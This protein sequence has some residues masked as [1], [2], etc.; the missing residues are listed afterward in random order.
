MFT[1]Y[2]ASAGS[3]KTTSLVAAYLALCFTNPDKYRNILAI[4]FTNNATAEMKKRITD[5]LTCFAFQEPKYFTSSEK[6]IY[7][8]TTQYLSSFFPPLYSSHSWLQNQAKILLNK[9]LYD[10][11]N[12]SISTID[13]FFQRLIR[14]F[15]FDLGL[16]INFN[17]QIELEELYA[18]TVDTLISK[19]SKQNKELSDRVLAVLHQQMENTGR[20]KIEQNLVGI[21]NASY[22]EEAY[23][24]LKAL[25]NMERTEF[26]RF[27][28]ELQQ[29]FAATKKE[30]LQLAEQGEKLIQATGLEIDDFVGVSRGIYPY[31]SKLKADLTTRQNNT[32]QKNDSFTKQRPIDPHIHAQ[33]CALLTQIQEQQTL[34]SEYY[35]FVQ[36]LVSLQL[37]FDLREIMDGIKLRD[38]LFYLSEANAKVYDEIKDQEA[39]YLYE[40]LGNKYFYF[41]IDEFQDTSQMQWKNIKPLIVNTISSQNSY[42]ELGNCAL[43]GDVKQAIYRFRNGDASLLQKLSSEDGFLEEFQ[44][45]KHYLD[46]YQLITLDTN[47]RSSRTVI[48]FNNAFFSFL[49]DKGVI[50]ENTRNYYFHNEQKIPETCTDEG[51]VKLEFM[52]EAR[53]EQYDNLEDHL[54][55]EAVKDALSHGFLFQDIAILVSGNQTGARLGKMLSKEAIPVISPESLQLS[56]SQDVLLIIA[57]LQYLYNAEDNLAKLFIF[58]YLNNAETQ[59]TDVDMLDV[60]MNNIKF[61]DFLKS[62]NIVISRKTLKDMP[63]FTMVKELLHCY[64]SWLSEAN[65][66]VISF[67]DTL[68]KYNEQFTSEIGAFLQWWEKT[69]AQCSISAPN[70]INAIT[71]NTIHKSKGLQYPIVI[72]PFSDF[73]KSNQNRNIWLANPYGGIPYLN[74]SLTKKTPERWQPL[75]EETQALNYTDSINLAYVAQTRA[76][77]G[78]Y[79]ITG[80]PHAKND[81]EMSKTPKAQYPNYLAQFLEAMQLSGCMNETS[82]PVSDSVCLGDASFSI[83]KDVRK[84]NLQPVTKIYNAPFAFSNEDI[85]FDSQKKS[86]EQTLGLAVHSYLSHLSDFPVTEADIAQLPIECEA[87]Y[88]EPIRNALRTILNDSAL[89]PYFTTQA[90]VMN[91]SAIITQEGEIYRPDRIVFLDD[92]VMVLDYKTGQPNEKYQKQIDQ[93]IH[94]LTEMGYRNVQGRLLYL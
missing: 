50:P 51:F 9:I 17:V 81:N 19:I 37:I 18:Q 13:S 47:W 77:K 66:F 88:H 3:G 84:V 71:I 26:Y 14:S 32:F 70:G 80:D 11:N 76:E 69:G 15:A 79:I 16:N 63:L 28:H 65:L 41:F 25:M 23:E 10:Y 54:V 34:Y 29:T 59:Q 6:A 33:L 48:Q 20:W 1:T 91:E 78:L 57:T 30:L 52:S 67:L 46:Y 93:Y 5:T 42:N 75:Y 87:C 45:D 53:K 72:L 89:Q 60:I 73:R 22:R 35:F 55:L 58:N 68:L 62:Y 85:S 39:P 64:A 36:S 92:E 94:L 49:K 7:Q 83:K 61:S 24:P 4:T 86:E 38:N 74:V 56:S 90:K 31:F 2:T 43:F 82:Q 40:K 27:C 12:F 44:F 21:I 8:Q